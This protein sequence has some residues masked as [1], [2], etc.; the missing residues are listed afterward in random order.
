MLSQN[1][2]FAFTILLSQNAAFRLQLQLTIGA[3]LI[4]GV[5]SATAVYLPALPP[6]VPLKITRHIETKDKEDESYNALQRGIVSASEANCEAMQARAE[7]W[8]EQ[9]LQRLRPRHQNR[10]LSTSASATHTTTASSSQQSAYGVFGGRN[11]SAALSAVRMSPTR[12]RGGDTSSSSSSSESSDSSTSSDSDDSNDAAK[13]TFILHIDDDVDEDAMASILDPRP[14]VDVLMCT[15]EIPPGISRPPSSAQMLTMLRRVTIPLPLKNQTFA[16]IFHD[17]QAQ[18]CFRVR[19]FAPCALSG[20]RIT[21]SLPSEST[22][23]LTLTATVGMLDRRSEEVREFIAEQSASKMPF[24]LPPMIAHQRA[25]AS[26]GVGINSSPTLPLQLAPPPPPLSAAIAGSSATSSSSSSS[27]AAAAAAAAVR[28]PLGL[29]VINVASPV[30]KAELAPTIRVDTGCSSAHKGGGDNVSGAGAASPS[31]QRL[32]PLFDGEDPHADPE[33]VEI[34]PL[35]HVP[36]S[37]V[38]AYLGRLQLHL[39]KETWSYREQGGLSAFAH[40]FVSEAHAMARAH[41]AARGGNALLSFRLHECRFVEVSKT[42]A[43]SIISLSGDCVRIARAGAALVGHQ[44]LHA[45]SM[46]WNDEEESA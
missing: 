15:T 1:L 8:R 12:A 36:A 45:S 26:A 33:F 27:S 38:E 19:R 28:A 31:A 41:V 5:M 11:T 35:T 3:Q 39:I 21:V 24:L 22:V 29:A 34:T 14:P 4:V 32:R 2:K 40:T 43:Y 20:M 23:E 16:A 10:T 37:L 42:Q 44:R 30:P 46:L 9:Q 25:G 6:P 13:Q 7:H 17:L 18:M